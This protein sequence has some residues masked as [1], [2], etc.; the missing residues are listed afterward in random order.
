MNELMK[1]EPLPL[2]TEPAIIGRVPTPWILEN[3]HRISREDFYNESLSED[4]LKKLY[5]N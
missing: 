2:P 1:Y 5:G 3:M 4:D